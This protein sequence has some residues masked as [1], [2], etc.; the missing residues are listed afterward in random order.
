LETSEIILQEIRSLRCEFNDHVKDTS[1]RLASLETSMR[2]LVGN[3]QPG[4]ITKIEEDLDSLK[5]FRYWTLGAGAVLSA[6]ITI[7]IE[8]FKK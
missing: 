7:I 1:E 3:G 4:R 6:L 5:G 8:L 2:S